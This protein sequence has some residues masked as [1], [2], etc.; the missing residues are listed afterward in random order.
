MKNKRPASKTAN[1]RFKSLS[2]ANA[3]S[4]KT[5]ATA[6]PC[7]AKPGR[8]VSS[9]R[10][11]WVSDAPSALQV[12]ISQKLTYPVLSFTLPP[13]FAIISTVSLRTKTE[14]NC[15][16]SLTFT[17]YL[18]T[19]ENRSALLAMRDVAARVC[20]GG[21]RRAENPLYLHGSVGTGKTHLIAALVDEATRKLPQ[22]VVTLLQA[23]DVAKAPGSQE[24]AGETADCFQAAK[25][26]DL[27]VLEDLQHLSGRRD[28]WTEALSEM[29]V[30]TFDYLHVRHRQLVFTATVGPRRLVHL[31][32]RLVSRLAC[33]LVVEIRPMERASRL[34]LLQDKAQR[35]QLAVGPEILAWLAEHILGGGRQLEGAL[36]QLE[37]LARMHGRPLDLPTVAH[38]FQQSIQANRLTVERIAQQVGNYFRV[39]VRHLQSKRRYQNVLLPRQISMYLARQLTGSSLEEIGSYFG[40][41]DHSTVLHACRK[42]RDVLGRDA[43]LSGAVKQLQAELV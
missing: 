18:P 15:I 33:G 41:R 13:H 8:G 21:S 28:D 43:V 6:D 11:G 1:P 42:I 32:A 4:A 27:F 37:A 2:V 25:Q 10:T 26:S 17:R 3:A 38:H 16:E 29:L 19:P 20:T 39:D 40:G 12:V 23:G 22:L 30:Q 34:A 9:V 35:R 31:P 14:E 5:R 36:L 7:R 24:T